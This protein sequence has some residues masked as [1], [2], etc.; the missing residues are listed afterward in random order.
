MSKALFFRPEKA[1]AVKK[2]VTG[3][4]ECFTIFNLMALRPGYNIPICQHPVP[5]V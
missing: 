5:A 4:L 3:H 1:A 2:V